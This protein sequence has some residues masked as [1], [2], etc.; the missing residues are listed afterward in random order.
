VIGGLRPPS[1]ATLLLGCGENTLP[2]TGWTRSVASLTGTLFNS[3]NLLPSTWLAGVYLCRVIRQAAHKAPPG[4][5][6]CA[7]DTGKREQG[8]SGTAGGFWPHHSVADASEPRQVQPPSYAALLF[9]VHALWRNAAG[10]RA[11]HDRGIAC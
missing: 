7:L 5:L 2:G 9:G 6:A 11:G 3:I 4:A 1:Y 10:T 8:A